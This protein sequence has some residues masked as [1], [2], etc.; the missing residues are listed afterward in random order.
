MRW[1]R[2]S[3]DQSAGWTPQQGR[4]TSLRKLPH[5][6]NDQKMQ[7]IETFLDGTVE[8]TGVL[9]A[10]PERRPAG[11][12]GNGIPPLFIVLLDEDITNPLLQRAFTLL[13]Q[14]GGVAASEAMTVATSWTTMN[15]GG[16]VAFV[17][18]KLEFQR[19]WQQRQDIAFMATN[20]AELWHQIA[21]GGLVA[22]TTRARVRA[23]GGI[24]ATYADTMNA[25]L[26]FSIAA[27]PALDELVTSRGW[28]T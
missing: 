12:A 22:L 3:P 19:P 7:E 5:A 17:K 14:Y 24:E 6:T 18:L 23:V 13:D 1:N 2:R 21:Q 28:P 27:S 10:A 16:P 26:L 11:A 4:V 8:A 15:D 9:V 25:S 20:Y